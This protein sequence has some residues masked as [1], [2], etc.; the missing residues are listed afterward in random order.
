MALRSQRANRAVEAPLN[1][2]V[3]RSRTRAASSRSGATGRRSISEDRLAELRRAQRARRA[4]RSRTTAI[5]SLAPALE[6]LSREPEAADR[7]VLVSATD[8]S[9]PGFDLEPLRPDDGPSAVNAQGLLAG[10]L[11]L[12]LEMQRTSNRLAAAERALAGARAGA[13]SDA[14]PSSATFPRSSPSS[15]GS[16]PRSAA[17]AA[18]SSGSSRRRRGPADTASASGSTASAPGCAEARAPSAR[19]IV[20]P[21]R[22]A[23]RRLSSQARPLARSTWPRSTTRSGACATTRA[24]RSSRRCA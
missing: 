13:R 1:G 24:R 18:A 20:S 4:R 6:N 14:R 15:P 21:L 8:E 23:K 3:G 19:A 11:P 2:D 17:S 9:A 16:R 22:R 10:A 12:A 7:G 5:G